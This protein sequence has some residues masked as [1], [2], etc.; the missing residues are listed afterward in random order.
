MGV[1]RDDVE[2]GAIPHPRH[3][4]NIVPVRDSHASELR[5]SLAVLELRVSSVLVSDDQP[6]F[7]VMTD[8]EVSAELL[9]DVAAGPGLRGSAPLGLASIQA[10]EGHL[11]EDLDFETLS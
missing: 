5:R 9:L 6:T 3:P 7:W 2:L 10:L 4:A 11:V 1:A 8:V